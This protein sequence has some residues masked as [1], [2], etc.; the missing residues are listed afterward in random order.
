MG[1]AMESA[2]L[3]SGVGSRAPAGRV[4]WHIRPPD[5]TERRGGFTLQVWGEEGYWHIV[6]RETEEL[7]EAVKQP[8]TLEELLATHPQWTGQRTLVTTTLQSIQRGLTRGSKPGP[9]RIESV[10]INLTT[11][12]NLRCAT[13]YVPVQDRRSGKLDAVATIAFLEKLRQRFSP[14]AT[15][16]LLGGE[17]FLH[18]EGVLA[19]A[20]WARRKGH[21]CNVSTNGTVPLE[22]LAPE[23]RKAGLQVQV[24]LD[25]A[26]AETNDA[27]RGPGTYARAL[28]T[29]KE[30]IAA[31]VHTTLCMVACRENLGE[32]GDY[33]RLVKALGANEA[34]VIPLKRLGNAG[35]GRLSPAPQLA[36]VQA[37]AAALAQEPTLAP[38]CQTDLHAIVRSLVKESSCRQSCGSG[39]QTLLLQADGSVYPCIN[40]TLAWARL[41]TTADDPEAILRKGAQWGDT[42]S[43]NSARHPCYGCAV[44]RWCLAGC[45][46]ETI[47]RE[48][49]LQSQHWDCADLKEAITWM[50]WQSSPGAPA[51]QAA[52]TRI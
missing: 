42:L 22:S 41:G 19:L 30:L 14:N 4:F 3:S 10:A 9:A 34:R 15:I 13:C 31:G 46:G 38:L 23:I 39:T 33:L 49:S 1:P 24:S 28:A 2:L 8:Q 6:D 50:M 40:G 11:A 43:V 18:P 21:A 12:C 26:R 52:R 36:I 25:G 7:L 44:K 17:P 32:I 45:P 37:I 16:V 20:R 48:G 27:L 5:H 29:A 47:Q 51:G 35:N